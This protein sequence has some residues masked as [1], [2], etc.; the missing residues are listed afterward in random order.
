MIS[1]KD[2]KIPPGE[3]SKKK[4]DTDDLYQF[5]QSKKSQNVAL[6][7]FIE[8]LNRDENHSINKK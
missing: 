2:K 6:K 8:N 7:K 4:D 3:T 1:K 5:I